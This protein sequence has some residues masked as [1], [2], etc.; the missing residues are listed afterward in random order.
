MNPL[1]SIGAQLFVYFFLVIVIGVASVGTISYNQSRV[2]IEDE[3]LESKRLT[4]IQASEKLRLVLTRYEEASMELMFIPEIAELSTQARLYPDDVIGQ[5]ETRRAIDSRLNTYV[6]S[7]SNVAAIHFLSVDPI[8]PTISQSGVTTESVQEADWFKKAL[9]NDGKGVWIPTALNGPSGKGVSS[10]GYARV[11]KDQS[12]FKPSY[13]YLMEIKEERLQS[14]VAGA[15]GEGSAMY[16]TDATNQIIS[17]PSKESMAQPFPAALDEAASEKG[18]AERVT[19]NGEEQLLVYHK[20]AGIGW[21]LVS[22]QPFAPLVEGTKT[23]QQLTV[24]MTLVGAVV[25]VLI[26]WMVAIRIGKPLQSIS[27]LM[28]KAES[29]DLNIEAPYQ[30][31]GDEIGTLANGFNEMI[32]NIRSLVQESH[33]SVEEVMKTAH[34][35]GEA[36][37]RTAT[38]AKEI[39]IA[40]EQIAIGASNVAVEAERVTDVTGVMGSRMTATVQANEQMASAASDIRKASQQGTE[41]MQDLSDKTAETEKLTTS[42]ASKVEELHKS[43][44]SIRDILQLLHNITKQTNILSLNATIE[45]ARAGEAGRGFMVVADEIRKLADQS[46]QS[47]DTVGAITDKIRT[48]IE[49]TVGL[50]GQAYPMFQQQIASVKQSNEIFVSVNDRMGDFVAE[51]DA[52][53]EAVL[54]LESTQ[55][56]LADAM[57]SVS[58]VAEESSA[59]TEEVASLSTDQLQVG[60]SLVGLAGRL[61]DVSVR[62][63]DTLNKFRL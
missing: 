55:R 32:R 51:L 24:A 53:S 22:V 25:A 6:F 52:V 50:M 34:E 31:R 57:A 9:E 7:D 21:K 58:A 60:E 42:M 20:L 2:L 14:I 36:S 10:F 41:Y 63:R 30:K 26:G 62:L 23:I 16:V 19:M 12:S 3:A 17:A 18:F 5:L 27:V 15:L 54:Q 28:K 46:K 39:A 8:L 49:Q 33:Q 61:D 37:R 44:A 56:T 29:G 38:S 35:L 47:I 45:A 4:A 48:E 13:I 11:V 43:T 59:T 1:R 40:T